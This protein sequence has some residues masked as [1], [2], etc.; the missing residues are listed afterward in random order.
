MVA[1][2]FK[3][4]PEAK[5][6]G[7]KLRQCYL[8]VSTQLDKCGVVREAQSRVNLGREDDLFLR[9]RLLDIR[10]VTPIRVRY[11]WVTGVVSVAHARH[12]YDFLKKIRE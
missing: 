8:K 6:V 10:S 7:R 1:K 4:G 12:S 3:P 2:N 11:R 5:D 9:A